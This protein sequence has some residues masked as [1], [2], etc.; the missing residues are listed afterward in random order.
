[1]DCTVTSLRFAMVLA[2]CESGDRGTTVFGVA[3]C[4]T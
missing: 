4:H 3:K 1:M 2:F